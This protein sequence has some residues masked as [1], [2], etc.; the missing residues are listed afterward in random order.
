MNMPR[1]RAHNLAIS[2]DGYMAGPNQSFDNPLGAG[3]LHLHH[4][5]FA[6]RSFRARR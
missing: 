6:T 2:L 1:L 5:A 4:W 3:G